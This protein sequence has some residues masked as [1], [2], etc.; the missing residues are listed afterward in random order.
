MVAQSASDGGTFEWENRTPLFAATEHTGLH[1]VHP[2]WAGIFVLAAL[3]AVFPGTHFILLDSD[4]LPVTLF[5]AAD[6]WREAFLTRF[7]PRSGRS[8]PMKHPLHRRQV[9]TRDPQVVYT[10]HRVSAET[11]GQGVLLLS[12]PHS[13]LNAGF[14]VVFGSSHPALFSWDDW[15]LRC[16]SLPDD[17]SEEM[18]RHQAEALASLFWARIGEFLQR[19]LGEGDLTCVEKQQWIQSGLALSPLMATCTQYSLDFCL[20]WAL[21]GEWTLRLLFQVPKGPWPRHGHTDALLSEYR[22]RCPRLVA[23]ARAAFEQG[24]LPSLLL[25]QGLVPIFTLPRDKM[26]QSTGICRG[27]QRP[28]IMHAYGGAKTGMTQALRAIEGWF[29]DNNAVKDMLCERIYPWTQFVCNDF[30]GTAS[31]RPVWSYALDFPCAFKIQHCRLSVTRRQCDC[32][33]TYWWCCWAGLA[34][35]PWLC[36]CVAAVMFVWWLYAGK[37]RSSDCLML[38]NNGGWVVGS[39]WSIVDCVPC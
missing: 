12:E 26:F 29:I 39:L 1:H 30:G 13:D 11:I 16:R 28:P 36:R 10:Q 31:R 9:Y 19:T 32:S 21:I 37:G 4:C 7:P 35:Q 6:L 22:T 3:V 5:E 20:A 24:A 27:R 23:W 38:F 33:Q 15:K 25:L 18:V 14:I 8:L 34:I 2:T 17:K